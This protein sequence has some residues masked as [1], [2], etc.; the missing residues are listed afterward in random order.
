MPPSLAL[1]VLTRLAKRYLTYLKLGWSK[2]K[3]GGGAAGGFSTGR[4]G[5]AVR[6]FGGGAT[7]RRSI[8]QPKVIDIAGSLAQDPVEISHPTY[9]AAAFPSR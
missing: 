2:P 5:A 1:L 7:P 8:R 9:W 3:D 4:V 6:T